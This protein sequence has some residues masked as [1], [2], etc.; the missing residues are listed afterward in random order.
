M[1]RSLLKVIAITFNNRNSRES[2]SG[3]RV[4]HRLPRLLRASRR[5]RPPLRGPVMDPSAP[6]PEGDGATGSG[7]LP[8]GR[9]S[10]SLHD[11]VREPREPCRDPPLRGRSVGPSR[12]RGK[13]E[14]S[15]PSCSH[16]VECAPTA[17]RRVPRAV[18]CPDDRA[19]CREIEADASRAERAR[20]RGGGSSPVRADDAGA[21]AARA[22]R[23]RS[24]APRAG[25]RPARPA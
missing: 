22:S 3:A 6:G 23:P 9:S 1:G 18:E 10:R 19:P 16:E 5:S 21:E 7:V 11:T 17:A 13:A 2:G 20:E 4:A 8:V 24:V 15:H 25:R 12:S 14:G